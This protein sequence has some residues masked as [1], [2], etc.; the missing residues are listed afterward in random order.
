MLKNIFLIGCLLVLI[1]FILSSCMSNTA[2]STKEI[3]VVPNVDIEKYLGKWYEIVRLPNSFEKGLF[4]ITATYSLLDNGQ[5]KV[6]NEGKKETKPDK[7]QKAEGRAWIPDKNIPGL[8]KVSFFLC[9]AADYKI[10][11][12]DTQ[13]YQYAVVTSNTK[14]YLWILSRTPIMDE[15]LYI[16]LISFCKEKGF[17]IEKLIRVKHE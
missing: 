8:L 14:K 9:F 7:R 11:K 15:P 17:E 4:N 5:I 1:I 10:I 12:L 16:E 3:Q 2:L 13:N 6:L